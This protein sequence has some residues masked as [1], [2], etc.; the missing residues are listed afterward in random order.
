MKHPA[1]IF[2][3]TLYLFY[4][5]VGS[6]QIDTVDNQKVK[7]DF[8]PKEYGNKKWKFILGLD[9]RR[10]FFSGVP[11]KI[12]GLRSGL[13]FRGVHRFGIGFY[14]LSRRVVFTDVAVDHP[15]ATDTS[16]VIFNVGYASLFYERVFY[17][18]RKWEFAIPTQLSGGTL[19]GHFEDTTGTFLPLV[20][21][22]FS[23]V[24]VGV[25]AK[26]YIFPWLAPRVSVGYRLSFN[27]TPEVK[28]AF[29]RPYY[30]FG[31]QILLGELYRTI[32]K[33]EEN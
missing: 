14:A 11:V 25:Q 23:A 18:T 33:K 7:S 9:A 21:S 32:F 22:P 31:V 8:F 4:P 6:S 16:R 28:K 10:S 19:T 3:L 15:A 5:S 2:L 12:N 24:N 30:S 29:N 17:K 1:V 20:E 27:T 13:Q 26:Y